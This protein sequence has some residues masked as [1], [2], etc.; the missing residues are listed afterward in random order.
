MSAA[1]KKTRNQHPEG[2]RTRREDKPVA[3]IDLTRC[4][5]APGCPVSRICPRQ[6]VIPDPDLRAPETS[7]LRGLLAPPTPTAWTVDEDRCTGCL[8]CAQYCPHQAVVPGRRT[9]TA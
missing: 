1:R 9:R 8:L 6:A 7:W 3:S 2:G 4:D 5:G